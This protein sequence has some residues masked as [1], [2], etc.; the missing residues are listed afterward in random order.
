[1]AAVSL[2]MMTGAWWLL[3]WKTPMMPVEDDILWFGLMWVAST[4]G[5]LVAWPLNYPM[6][7][8]KLKMGGV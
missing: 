8:A 3:M 6:V 4:A 2:G 1:M 7:R 5:F